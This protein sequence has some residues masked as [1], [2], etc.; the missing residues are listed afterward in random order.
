MITNSLS[1]ELEDESGFGCGTSCPGMNN[2]GGYV[3]FE[4]GFGPGGLGCNGGS[5][6]GCGTSCPGM[7]NGGDFSPGNREVP[8]SKVSRV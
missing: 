8:G 1:S 7:S 2:G 4:A 3:M 6:F 5:D